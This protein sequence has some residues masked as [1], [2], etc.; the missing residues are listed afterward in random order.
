MW[1]SLQAFSIFGADL[2]VCLVDAVG[3][4]FS[5]SCPLACARLG[6]DGK[7]P[8]GS[9]CIQRPPKPQVLYAKFGTSIN[10]EK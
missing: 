7:L 10:L 3:R 4:L 9:R 2:P 1:L 6:N 8:C 5:G